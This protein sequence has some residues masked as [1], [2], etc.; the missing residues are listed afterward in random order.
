MKEYQTEEI[1]NISF[2]GHGS[3]GKTTLSEAVIYTTGTFNR[4][5]EVE[6]GTTHSDYNED[7]IARKISISTSLLHGDWKGTK[8]N[9][10]DTPG[11]DDFNGEVLS[12]LRASDTT[13]ILID[14]IAGV[15]VGTETVWEFT[16]NYDQARAFF[17]N[18]T[19]KEHANYDSVLRKLKDRFGHQ[20]IPVLLPIN[21]GPGFNGVVDIVTMKAYT[22]EPGGKGKGKEIAIPDELK[23][24]VDELREKVIEA[25][26]ESDDLLMEKYF[27]GEEL[28]G[29]EIIAGLREAMLAK[30]FYPVFCGDAL[31][32]VGADRLLDHIVGFFPTPASISPI[33]AKR[34]SGDEEIDVPVAI[35]SNTTLLIFKTV[36]EQHVGE[37]SFFRVFTG[38]VSS[39][40]ELVNSSSGEMEKIGQMHFLNGRDRNEVGHIYA[41]DIGAFVK[42]RNTHTGDTLSSK[43]MPL[44]L[45]EIKFP[46]PVIRIAVEPKAKG[47][48]D[49]IS[50][51]LN[52]LRD[53]DPS[54]QFTVDPE[55]KQTILSGQGGLQLEIIIERLK[56]KF[57]VDVDTA[58]PRIPYREA[59]LGKAEDSYRHKK[60]SGGRGQFGEVWFRMAPL[61]RGTGF[62][63]INK[64]KG[65]SIPSKYIPAVE[66]G[67]LEAMGKGPQTGSKVID[68]QI[69]VY[70]G[71]F[72]SVDSSELAFKL[73]AINC[74][75]KC[76]LN[77]RPILLEPI[78]TVEVVV[79][80]EFMGDV[81]GDL[82]ARRG[83][84]LGM[85]QKGIF[86]VVKAHVPLAELYQ[87][88][89]HLRSLTQG[90]GKHTREF[91]YY[92]QIPHDLQE[93]VIEKLKKE[94]ENE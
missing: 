71:K 47:D 73:A 20:V 52:Q 12:G 82:S 76:F 64:I 50:S 80:E 4:Q 49:K 21:P 22:Y 51:G 75:K 30:T 42:L 53:V 59:I 68:V 65:G 15:E 19:G 3:T 91:S 74:F 10:I 34:A 38:K 17:I 14:A 40:D 48:E 31:E 72:H 7:E 94:K 81:M 85:E 57:G 9:L 5:G 92:E 54:F 69:T 45:P 43:Q 78:Y 23:D 37:L 6:K 28:S 60:Q 70:D 77:A 41:G 55:L 11:Y 87:Y 33:K 16:G 1:R 39:G 83:K 27:E 29:E 2:A 62:E 56:K 86:Q 36:A 18:R 44:L 25:A 66:K 93:T 8:I 24:R 13:L 88:S 89:T 67:S 90:R 79:T 32:N 63:F 26:A 46:A 61:P 84:I 35:D 58:E